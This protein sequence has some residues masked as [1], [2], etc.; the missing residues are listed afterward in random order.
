MEE[1]RQFF[2]AKKKKK[3]ENMGIRMGILVSQGESEAALHKE[4]RIQLRMDR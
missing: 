4:A 2:I 3:R 1:D